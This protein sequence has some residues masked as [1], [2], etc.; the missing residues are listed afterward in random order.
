MLVAACLSSQDLIA[1]L[2]I[3]QYDKYPRI[4]SILLGAGL[5]ND[6]VVVTLAEVI[7][8][9][10]NEGSHGE[11]NF[12]HLNLHI[13]LSFTACAFFS[14]MI[15]AFY[16][17]LSALVFK[18]FRFMTHS[19]MTETFTLLML[20]ILSY[21]TGE[22]THQSGILSIIVTAVMMS[23]YTWYNISTQGKQVSAITFKTL[24]YFAEVMVFSTLGF[25]VIANKGSDWSFIFVGALFLIICVGRMVGTLFVQYFFLLFGVKKTLSFKETFF[26]GYGGIIRG[27]IAF[28]LTMEFCDF[29]EQ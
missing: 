18:H 22:S 15:G 5:W 1:S 27:A 17:G 20:G 11:F 29:P 26:I 2:S 10:I 16:G 25:A 4:F 14:I 23:H 3:V 9:I 13:L 6:A 12:W 24:G 7:H 8:S 21:Y 19:P 28:G